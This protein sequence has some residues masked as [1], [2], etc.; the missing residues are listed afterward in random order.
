MTNYDINN[1]FLAYKQMRNTR[2]NIDNASPM[3]HYFLM[4]CAYQVY[5]SSI[6]DL[7][8]KQRAAQERNK[9]K[10]AFHNYFSKVHLAFNSEQLDYLL[11]KVDAFQ[12]AISDSVEKCKK[13]IMNCYEKG[14]IENRL[15]VA[16][17]W[18]I[19]TLAMD[20][21]GYM[22]SVYYTR[23]NNPQR[24]I[25]IDAVITGSKNLAKICCD[26]EEIMDDERVAILRKEIADFA[27]K[28]CDWVYNDYQSNKK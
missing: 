12:V 18:L 2:G 19:N 20:A 14:S 16:E 22:R 27:R 6:K 10:R 17:L 28:I 4:D 11:D 24:D 9:I 26:C 13:A 7:P 8:L 3:M 23:K 15:L 5:C 21:R 1:A 25:D